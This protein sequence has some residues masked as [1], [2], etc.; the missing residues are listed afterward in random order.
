[1]NVHNWIVRIYKF[2]IIDDVSVI[3]CQVLIHRKTIVNDVFHQFIFSQTVRI[4]LPCWSWAAHPHNVGDDLLVFVYNC[5]DRVFD[6]EV[7]TTVYQRKYWKHW[8]PKAMLLPG[9]LERILQ[10]DHNNN[11]IFFD[12]TY[13]LFSRFFIGIFLFLIVWKQNE[14]KKYCWFSTFIPCRFSIIN[15]GDVLARC[16]SVS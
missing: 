3:S 12:N 10:A 2:T 11:N 13:F 7:E 14:D 9:I 8:D 5:G 15:T 4:Q 1:M 16:N 6:W